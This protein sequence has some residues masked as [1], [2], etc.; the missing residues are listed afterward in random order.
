MLPIT[1]GFCTP[2]TE[3]TFSSY[4]RHR[5]GGSCDLEIMPKLCIDK[6]INVAYNEILSE[7]KN[8]II[9]LCHNDITFMG[10]ADVA[11][12]IHSLFESFTDM[13]IIGVIGGD[14]ISSAVPNWC[15]YKHRYGQII[16]GFCNGAEHD[17]YDNY[18]TPN[19]IMQPALTV[20]GLFMAVRR[21]RLRAIFDEQIKTFHFYDMCF[22]VDNHL[23][24][25]KIGI[26][27]LLLIRHDSAGHMDKAWH[28]TA[29][30]FKKKYKNLLPI[31]I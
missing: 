8:D 26:T 3:E 1:I 4:L 9:I 19:I 12:I 21:D 11:V 31:E 27:K 16:Q 30:Y 7:A 24:G 10:N 14:S 18:I 23:A 22:C 15:G 13:A 17:R 28:E 2:T 25:C 29:E 6:N 5:V 20:D